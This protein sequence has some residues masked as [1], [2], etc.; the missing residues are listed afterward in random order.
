MKV[1][2]LHVSDFHFSEGD[3]YDRNV[4][5]RAL[6]ESVKDFRENKGRAPDLIFATGDIAYSGKPEE[7]GRAT[8]LFDDLLKA[9]GLER[10]RLYII[11]G[12]HDVNR[13]K[14][15]GLQRTL[16]S[17]DESDSYFSQDRLDHLHKV[18]KEFVLWYNN[19][20]HGIRSFPE[21][22]TCGPVEGV[23]MGD[24]MIGLL[25]INSALFCRDDHDHEKLWLGRRCLDAAL[26]ALQDLGAQV[27]IALVHHPLYS[28]HPDERPNI[29]MKIHNALDFV[30]RGHLHAREAEDV[31]TP[32]GRS[33]H[34]SAGAAYESV[35]HVKEAFY[36]RIEGQRAVVFPIRYEAEP[37]V[38]TVD[39]SLFP[40]E[41]GYEKSFSVPRLTESEPRQPSTFV[42]TAREPMKVYQVPHTIP[43]RYGRPFIGRDE[44][45]NEIFVKLGDTSRERVVVVHGQPGTGKSELACEFARGKEASYPGG[46][47]FVRAGSGE[48]F[49]DLASIGRNIL[50]LNF[51]PDLKLEDQGRQTLQKLGATPTLLIYDNVRSADEVRPWLPPDGMPCHVL[52]TTV[53]ER[54]DPGWPTVEVKPL[55]AKEA[56]NLIEALGSRKIAAEYGQDLATLAGGLP[57]Q[58]CPVAAALRQGQLHGPI[59]S[60]R[61]TLAHEAEQ[62]FRGVYEYLDQSQRLLLHASAHLNPQRI[63][64]D[65]LFRHL[66]EP[67]GFTKFK[68]QQLLDACMDLHLLEGNDELRM[69]QLFATFLLGL[70]Q[71]AEIVA[72]LKE[73]RRVQAR[74]LTE[75]AVELADHPTRTE[76]AA[77]LMIFPLK[78][79]AWADAKDDISIADGESIGRALLE[80]GRP[81]DALP[82][83]ERAVEAAEKGDMYGR[84]DNA[85]LGSSLHQVGVCL[86]ETGRYDEALPWYERAVEAKKKGDVFG[87]V[88]NESLAISLRGRAK[89][90]RILERNDEADACEAEAAGLD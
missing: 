47:F 51:S 12:N 39:A 15:I 65:E 29:K 21:D 52:I 20:F 87:R 27:N 8:E 38:W 75:I 88:N 74:R 10:H 17:V 22:S 53:L 58:I 18:Q 2:W 44:E 49:V 41:P 59:D 11:P 26:N 76:L 36:C 78:P 56:L 69:H 35:K 42:M 73:V 81:A 77:A 23:A 67:T 55:P 14:C 64:R 7:Y 45:L 32:S 1:T 68:L 46:R 37:E 62:S 48:A 43:S 33:L 28:L 57:V 86:S 25:P 6:V 60:F 50:D 84:V 9:A 90:L 66:G 16:E 5:L 83:Y 3:S 54:W 31:A 72:R 82:W 24:G 13:G 79:D 30:L 80:I 19:Y 40:H 89:L 34:F 70:P 85:S 63:L 71:D 61:L 4:V